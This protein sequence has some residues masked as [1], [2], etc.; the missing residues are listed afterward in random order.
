MDS[1]GRRCL[2]WH[3]LLAFAG[4]FAASLFSTAIDAG[5]YEQPPAFQASQVLPPDLLRG[6]SYTVAN[7]VGLDDFQ[8]VFQV[9]TAWG[10]FAIR[11]SDLLRIRARE[12]AATAKLAQI[13]SAGTLVGAA[14][15]TALRPLGT[16]KGLL[17][18]PGK[19]IGDTVQG[20]GNLFGSVDASMGATDPNKEKLIPSLTGGAT[21]RRK[22]A[23][24]FGVDPN[25]RFP[26]LGD[27]LTRLA[28]A[29]A[30]G[31]TTTNVGL[32]FVTGG[33][34]IAISATS[35]SQKLR[36]ALRDKT[37]A[38][39]E[40]TGRQFLAE[41]GVTGAPV[42]AFYA[43][44]NLSPTDKAIIVVALR[45][46]DGAGGRAIFLESA[47]RAQNIEMGFFYRRQAELIA[48][49]DKNVAPVAA[50]VRIGSA[51]M[52]QTSKG[53]VSVLPVDYLYWS[54][55][56]ESL[57]AGGGGGQIWIT[58]RASKLA[59]SRLAARGW[60]LQAKA[61]ARLGE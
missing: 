53:T 33:A 55:P 49:Y 18:Q 4:A 40:Q 23:Y 30:I 7:Q 9:D 54:P 24:D 26:P 2:G 14:G 22:L 8:Y 10:Q 19:T 3:A 28:T 21:A 17:T 45:Q 57:V 42:Q 35:T 5:Q 47:A 20:V 13:D 39:L 58:G 46:L 27:E 32:A 1:F 25:T 61:G 38:Q 48:L 6:P 41:M 43:N 44:P 34:G 56:L 12:I 60:T 15:R 16:A 11:G 51:P 37:A 29:N 31:E 59:T 36:E 50:F 52:L